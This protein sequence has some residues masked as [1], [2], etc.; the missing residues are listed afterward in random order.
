MLT[1]PTHIHP[2][3]VYKSYPYHPQNSSFDPEFSLAAEDIE[4][5][6]ESGFTVVRLYVAWPGVEPAEGIYNSTYLDVCVTRKFGSHIFLVQLN[7]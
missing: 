3:Q 4:F 7:F 1:K 6:A 2:P 5:L